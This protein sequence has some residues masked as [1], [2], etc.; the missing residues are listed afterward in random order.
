MSTPAEILDHYIQLVETERQE[1]REQF[2][3]RFLETPLDQR[4]EKGTTLYPVTIDEVKV[5]LGDRL[6]VEIGKPKKEEPSYVFQVG[7]I[8]SLWSNA[9]VKK[10]PFVTGVITKSGAQ[11]LVVALDKDELPD[12]ADDGKLGLDLYYDERTLQRDAEGIEGD[13]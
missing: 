8:V 11:D 2:R 7:K 10:K 9:D 1:E 4:L 6:L 12:W 3:K 13:G 5:G